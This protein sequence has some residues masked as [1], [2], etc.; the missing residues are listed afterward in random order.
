[1]TGNRIQQAKYK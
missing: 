1:M